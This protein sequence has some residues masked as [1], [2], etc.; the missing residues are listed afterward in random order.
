MKKPLLFIAVITVSRL[1]LLLAGCSKKD[2]G[3][4]YSMASV[5]GSYKLTS[6]TITYGGVTQDG[7]DL[8]FDPCQQDDIL[9]LKADSSFIYTDAGTTCSSDGSYTGKWYISGSYLIQVVGQEKDTANI[10]SFNGTALVLTGAG[11]LGGVPFTAT[12]TM[13]KQ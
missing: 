13:T 9:Q 10:K 1:T 5:A 3:S 8:L 12:T 7:M 11:D 6:A 4:S 2:S